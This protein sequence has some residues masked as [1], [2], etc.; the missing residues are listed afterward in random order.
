MLMKRGAVPLVLSLVVATVA[1]LVGCQPVM[2]EPATPELANP[3]SVHC[4]EE[5]GTLEIREGDDGGQIGVCVFDD[6]SECEEWAF[7]RGEC[8]PGA[9]RSP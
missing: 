7:Y 3:A 8:E 1:V 5:G 4:V 2:P 9:Q 6:G